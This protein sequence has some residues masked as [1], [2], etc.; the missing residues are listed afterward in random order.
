VA[1][2]TGEPEGAYDLI[3]M[4][5]QMPVLDGYEAA[6]QIRRLAEPALAAVPILALSADVSPALQEKA[7]A[8]GMD[9][10]ATKPIDPAQ[11]L[12]LYTS[13]RNEP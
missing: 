11:I 8:A 2:Y 13:L 12:R 4:D 5:I 1:R 7:R 9:G 10:Y 3:L 6:G